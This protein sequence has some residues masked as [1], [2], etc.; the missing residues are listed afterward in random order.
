LLSAIRIVMS[1]LGM[2]QDPAKSNHLLTNGDVGTS[3]AEM[4]AINFELDQAEEELQVAEY[5]LGDQSSTRAQALSAALDKLE[6]CPVAA[7]VQGIRRLYRPE[8]T[9]SLINILRTELIRD[10]WTTRYLDKSLFDEDDAGEEEEQNGSI[11]TIADLLCRCIDSVR[12][13]GW[14]ANET[15]LANFGGQHGTAHFFEQLKM[16]VNAARE[17]IEEAF[18]LRAL[19]SQVVSYG[20]SVQ[21]V[22]SRSTGD[23][24]A[25]AVKETG[26]KMLPLKL[27]GK[28]NVPSTKVASGGE[29]KKLSGREKRHLN[30]HRV[31]P[32]TL[33]K[34]AI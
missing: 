24:V 31:G 4:T 5:Y 32:Y 33:E 9:L 10:G 14:L 17:G 16:E 12:P 3:D 27:R 28:E 30:S 13:S 25:V 19:L 22:A 8:E 6:T 1:S 26:E 21:E 2:V 20:K 7:T 15:L 34:I 18:Q 29:V 11:H 23:A